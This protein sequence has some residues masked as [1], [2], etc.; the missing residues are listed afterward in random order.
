[1]NLGSRRG[2]L[3]LS[4]GLAGALL[5][6]GAVLAAEHERRISFFNTHTG[7]RLSTVYWADGALVPEAMVEINKIL[8][9]YRTDESTEMD[10]RLID[11]LYR[12]RSFVGSREPYH[13][14]SG[15]RSPKTNE[16]LR[17]NGKG[18]AK[19]SFHLQGKAIDAR[20]PGIDLTKLRWKARALAA[21][22]VGF[23]PVSDFVHVDTGPVRFW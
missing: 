5:A 13:I 19:N 15:Y 11:T 14:V 18:V 6:P 21:G 23:Y 20:L 16:A 4:C 7:E 2:F 22:G 17:R 8:R 10:F 9:D 1:M 3:R 12:L